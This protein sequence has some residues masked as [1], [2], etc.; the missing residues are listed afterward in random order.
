MEYITKEQ[1]NE[2]LRKVCEKWNLGYKDS[3]SSKESSSYALFHAF[4]DI[5][6]IKIPYEYYGFC[7]ETNINNCYG[8]CYNCDN[9]VVSVKDLKNIFG[10]K[11][12][13]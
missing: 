2:A 4:D 7:A 6:G 1:A 5:E 12:E 10:E 3:K 8:K 13:C 11:D 9:Y